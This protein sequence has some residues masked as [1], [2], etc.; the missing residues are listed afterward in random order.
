VETQ[1]A[2]GNVGA[3]VKILGTDLTGAT[4]V[5]FNGITAEFEVVSAS[6]IKAIVPTGATTRFGNGDNAFRHA[7][8]QQAIPGFAIAMRRVPRVTLTHAEIRFRSWIS[9]TG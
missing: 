7:D 8:Q 2:F 3:V 1:T 5:T 4:G 6:L 9:S